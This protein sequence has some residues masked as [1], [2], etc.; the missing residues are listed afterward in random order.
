MRRNPVYYVGPHEKELFLSHVATRVRDKQLGALVKSLFRPSYGGNRNCALMYTLGEL[1][2][3]S[4]DDMRPHA[5]MD[6]HPESLVDL[7]IA[8]GRLLPPGSPGS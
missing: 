8:H 1:V 7:E 4:D 2:V 5:L 6:T 3:S